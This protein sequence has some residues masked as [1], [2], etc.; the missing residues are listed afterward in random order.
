MPET[1]NQ[2]LTP[3][4]SARERL[5]ERMQQKYPDRNFSGV[6]GENGETG[7]D[8]LEQSVMDA[9][10]ELED[11]RDEYN[12]KN[13]ALAEL[14]FNDPSAAQF[15]HRWV[16]TG[17]PR[18]ALVETFGDELSDLA[19]EEGRSRFSEGLTA[20]RE[21]KAQNDQLNAEADANWNTTL[22]SLNSWGDEKGL[23]EDEKVKIILRLVGI[24]ANGLMNKYEP[25]DFEMVLKEQR[26][27]AAI[28]TAKNEGIIEGKNAKIAEAK[29]ARQSVGA[30][31]P[32]LNGQGGKP[33]RE[34]EE[35]S[36]FAGIE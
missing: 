27:D 17:D 14:M 6:A 32:S 16:A 25:A 5:I 20:W 2:E 4:P 22:E 18:T 19:T 35:R 21:K 12:T 28:E 36:V 13:N 30:M 15:I 9:L 31:P 33:R 10:Q 3:V 34:P 11:Q 24:A 23:T 8:I 7:G 26:Y 29:A 1:E